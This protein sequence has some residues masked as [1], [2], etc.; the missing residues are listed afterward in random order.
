MMLPQLQDIANFDAPEFGV[1]LTFLGNNDSDER[2]Y[3]Q[4]LADMIDTPALEDYS[5]DVGNGSCC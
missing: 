5:S 1:D 2:L 4:D 3:L